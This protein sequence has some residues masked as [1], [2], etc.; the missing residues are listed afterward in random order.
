MKLA[1]VRDKIA[2]ITGQNE[3]E[4]SDPERRGSAAWWAERRRAMRTPREDDVEALAAAV[5]D[6]GGV[7]M[8]EHQDLAH[9][10]IENLKDDGRLAMA[11][12]AR[13]QMGRVPKL[14]RILDAANLDLEIWQELTALGPEQLLALKASVM[15]EI[16][17]ALRLTDS[18]MKNPTPLAGRIQ[19]PTI[20]PATREEKAKRAVMQQAY[21]THN[22]LLEYEAG[23]VTR[24]KPIERY[25]GETIDAEV[26]SGGRDS[27]GTDSGT[28]PATA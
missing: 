26:V 18:V 28:P 24:P 17:A 23:V 8:R 2:A 13:L 16:S 7:L 22:L 10:V 27:S 11:A 21:L 25:Q 15:K 14:M 6:G 4:T 1:A 9:R 19:R 12:F 3:A 5:A 20:D